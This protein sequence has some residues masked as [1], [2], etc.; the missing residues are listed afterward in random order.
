MLLAD[1]LPTLKPIALHHWADAPIGGIACRPQAVPASAL[2][3]VIDEFLHYGQWTQGAALPLP[4]AQIAA[5]IV[6][7]PLEGIALPQIQVKNS[8]QALAQVAKQFYHQP[9]HR[10][11]ITGITGTNGKTTT[12]YLINQWLNL[13]GQRAAALGTLG[14]YQ[15]H[16]PQTD[17]GYTTPLAPELFALLADL[18][19]QAI[20][21]LAMEISSHALKLDRVFGLAVEVA[22]FTNLSRDHLDFHATEADYKLS[23]RRLFTTLQPTATAVINQEDA[24][25]RELIAELQHHHQPLIRYGRSPQADLWVTDVH[26]GLDGSRFQCHYQQQSLDF[27]LPLLGAFNVD[28]ALAAIA[29]CLSQGLSLQQLQQTA[30]QLKG[31]PGRMEMFALNNGAIGVVDYAHTPDALEKALFTLR[32]LKPQRIITIFGC[33]GDRDAG[34]RPLMGQIAARDSDWVIVTSDNPRRED[35]LAIIQGILGGMTTAN[36]E[37]ISD[38]YQAIQQGYALTQTG[39]VL[40]VAGKGHETYQIIGDE[41]RPFSDRAELLRLTP[42]LSPHTTPL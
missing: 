31:A 36:R 3:A 17:L 1:F 18:T 26:S 30:S 24:F 34:K 7:Q 15:F 28:N 13:N 22:I 38:R 25:G 8:R 27:Y 9:D 32:C 40:L 19:T 2:Y 20:T 12:A 35:P 21:H 14:L 4:L 37:I 6:E 39:D 33:G 10:L 5:L 41:T 23:K 11:K 29:A 16:T 42:P